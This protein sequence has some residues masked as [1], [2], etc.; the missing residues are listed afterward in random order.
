MFSRNRVLT[1]SVQ[2]MAAISM[3]SLSA[4]QS[5]ASPP[6]G[7]EKLN[8]AYTEHGYV[9]SDSPLQIA[10]TIVSKRTART[11]MNERGLRNGCGD[12]GFDIYPYACADPLSNNYIWLAS[13]TAYGEDLTLEPGIWTIG[14]YDVFYYADNDPNYG[15]NTNRT[16]T[17]SVHESCN[18]PVIPGSVTT[19]TVPPHGGPVLLTGATTIN[20][21]AS[22]TIWF[23]ITTSINGCDGWYVSHSNLA[24][25]TT[26]DVQ[27]GSNCSEFID[28]PTY[29][30]FHVVL[31][32]T[33]CL[34][35]EITAQPSGAEICAG[36]WHQMCITATGDPAP[37]YQWQKNGVDIP[38]ADSPCY[39][40]TE[41]GEYQ[42]AVS[43]DCSN[44]TSEPA[45]VTIKNGP[46][47]NEQPAG[48]VICPGYLQVLCVSATGSGE[49]NYLWK[50]NNLTL[51]GSNDPCHTAT[52]SGNYTCTI[53][54]DC[55]NTTSDAAVVTTANPGIGDFSGDGHSD[56]Q[57]FTILH[58][59][60]FG[61]ATAAENECLCTD[62]D[63]NGTIDLIDFA[64]LQ[65]YFGS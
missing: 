64:L 20:F 63:G 41:A 31:Y 19:W 36:D 27:M 17:I 54:D 5:S 29:N 4:N 46:T 43:N 37:D 42:C 7:C 61:P 1:T 28:D 49:M 11:V 40:A 55:G 2:I 53:T 14:C 52:Q 65:R 21:E 30:R 44:E 10:N 16:V 60:L 26:T 8:R 62:V 47:I 25:S 33:R 24:G 59:C 35:V 56:I 32:G 18:G 38:G 39:V 23:T 6:T 51:I 57:D 22:G 34:P 50:R 13:N 3:F 48:G 58:D 9:N 12:L 15:C 45:I